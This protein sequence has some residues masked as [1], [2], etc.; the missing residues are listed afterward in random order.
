MA[1]VGPLN[2][3]P[4]PVRPQRVMLF[5][6]TGS[7]GR[8]VHAA[9]IAKGHD[10]VCFL[11]RSSDVPE[12]ISDGGLRFGDVSDL[13]SLIDDGFRGEQFDAVISCMASRTGEPRDAWAVD[14]EAHMTALMAAKATGV[15]RFVLLSAICVQKPELAFQKAKLAFEKALIGSGLGYSVVRPTAFFKSLSGQVERVMAGKPYLLFGDGTRTACKPISDEDLAVFIVGCLTDPDLQ[16]RI[17]PIGGPGPAITP[18]EQGEVLFR[19]LNK[20]PKFSSFPFW[21]MDLIAGTL[22]ALG[23]V[24]P[25]LKSKAALARIGRYY[26]SESMLMWDETTGSYDADATPET[27]SGTLFDYYEELITAGGVVERGEHKVF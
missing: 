23:T 21:L 19:L 5:G 13:D 1:E 12:A 2:S 18:R 24:I 11:R 4:D 3:L 20:P 25:P 16:N 6:A 10:V 26:A 14:Y 27:G 17:L 9:L 22:G 8:A 7:I 15:D